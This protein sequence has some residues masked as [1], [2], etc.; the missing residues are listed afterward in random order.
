MNKR[1]INGKFLDIKI[2][3][4]EWECPSC[5]DWS[6]SIEWRVSIEPASFY[7]TER[8]VKV[9]CPRCLHTETT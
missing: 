7:D 1:E 6:N 9:T 2:T 5:K 8:V 3:N 4:E